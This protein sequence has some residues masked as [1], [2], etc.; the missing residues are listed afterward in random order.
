MR[1]R[2]R[3]FVRACVHVVGVIVDKPTDLVRHI[4]VCVCVRAVCV[5]VCVWRVF[6]CLCQCLCVRACDVCARVRA[7]GVIV[8]KSTDLL[9]LLV[10]VR[11]LNR[12]VDVGE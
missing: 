3:S 5:R 8:G 2:V 1:V 12:S 10:C 4:V 6:V 9:R 7:V 11:D